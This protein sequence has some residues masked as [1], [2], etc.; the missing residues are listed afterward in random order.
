MVDFG[1][2]C[3]IFRQNAQYIKGKSVKYHNGTQSRAHDI[4]R[5]CD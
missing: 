1:A 2:P 3:I 5:L 4:I